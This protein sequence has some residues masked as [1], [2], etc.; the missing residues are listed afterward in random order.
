MRTQ[1]NSASSGELQ[2]KEFRLDRSVLL[3]RFSLPEG[4]KHLDVA[5]NDNLN[6]WLKTINIDWSSVS[7]FYADG[8][9]SLYI[10]ATPRDLAVIE[11]AL[12]PLLAK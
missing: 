12:K 9:N 7:H 11:A 2:W 4:G 3:Q 5:F 8:I 6:K 1:R 10:D